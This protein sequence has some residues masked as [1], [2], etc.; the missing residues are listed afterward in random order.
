MKDSF[1]TPFSTPPRTS[2]STLGQT[3]LST[4]SF[5]ISRRRVVTE[6]SLLPAAD[7]VG[8]IQVVL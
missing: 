2:F 7:G 1:S 3:L 8:V 5:L 6:R 4:H